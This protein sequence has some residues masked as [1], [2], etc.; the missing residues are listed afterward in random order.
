ML[1]Q[2]A[3]HVRHRFGGNDSNPALETFD[4]LLDEVEEDPRDGE[5]VGVGV[6]HESGWA[7][8]VYTGWAVCLENVDD[9]DVEP[10]HVVVGW[11]RPRVLRLMRAAAAGDVAEL[12]AEAWQPGYP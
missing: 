1:W 5:H 11:D 12:E 4:A 3:F 9:L 7:V 8:G 10:R 2:M 6:V